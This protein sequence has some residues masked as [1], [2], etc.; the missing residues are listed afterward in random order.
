VLV[1]GVWLDQLRTKTLHGPCAIS[2]ACGCITRDLTT[3][4]DHFKTFQLQ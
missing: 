1:Y 2:D 3:T 4:G